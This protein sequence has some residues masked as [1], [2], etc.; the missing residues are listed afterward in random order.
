MMDLRDSFYQVM[1]RYMWTKE[2][3]IDPEARIAGGVRVDVPPPPSWM[4]VHL[5]CNVILH[6]LYAPFFF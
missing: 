5:F 6:S 3:M 1:C 4:K 2:Q